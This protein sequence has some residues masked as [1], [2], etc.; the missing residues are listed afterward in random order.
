VAMTADRR[1]NHPDYGFRAFARS[2][3]TA[4][5]R[6]S[7]FALSVAVVLIWAASGP[8]FR[9]SDTWQLV[10][11][12]GTTV[13]TFWMVFVIQSSQ[14]SDTH[15]LQLKLDE[16]IRAT[17]AARNV[18]LGCEGLPDEDLSAFQTEFI[19][20]QKRARDRAAEKSRQSDP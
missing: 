4:A 5:G 19:A 2:V 20:L 1:T 12:T 13:V 6:P 16:L 17:D 18:F 10:I 8:F 14:N 15:A 7:A 11:N 3:S 9:F